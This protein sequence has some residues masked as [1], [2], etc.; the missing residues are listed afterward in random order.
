MKEFAAQHDDLLDWAP[1]LAGPVCFPRLKHGLSA[2]AHC[3]RVLTQQEGA[4]AMLIPEGL[5]A[6][7]GGGGAGTMGAGRGRAAQRTS[8]WFFGQVL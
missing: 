5:F 1:P 2:E 6:A 4:G 3:A 8:R 7:D